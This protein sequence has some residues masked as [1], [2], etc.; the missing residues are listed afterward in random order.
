[1]F[2]LDVGNGEKLQLLVDSGAD[3]SWVKSRRLLG[4]RSSNL[5]TGYE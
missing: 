4:Q 1:M 2:D 5:E 3:I